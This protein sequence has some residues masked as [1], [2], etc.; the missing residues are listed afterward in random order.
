MGPGSEHKLVFVY[1][2]RIGQQ[3]TII[4]VNTV[5]HPASRRATVRPSV[6]CECIVTSSALD[7]TFSASRAC[8]H[9]THGQCVAVLQTTLL[10]H[11]ICKQVSFHQ[12]TSNCDTKT[13][14][15]RIKHASVEPSSCFR[16]NTCFNQL[17]LTIGRNYACRCCADACV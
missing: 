10:V 12:S 9:L 15:K 7:L 11:W 4:I 1:D 17:K 6:H 14:S 2:S 16:P 8:R 3:P 13:H 5:V